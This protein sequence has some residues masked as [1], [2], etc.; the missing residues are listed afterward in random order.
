MTII[1]PPPPPAPPAAPPVSAA[2]PPLTPGGRTAVRV[3]LVI[4]ASVVVVGT[5]LSLGATAWGVSMF[6]VVADETAF[7]SD[8][9]SLVID[10]GDVPAALRLRT[11]RDAREPR[12]SMRLLKS[13]RSGERTL[14]VNQDAQTTRITVNG[15]TPEFMGWGRAGEIT[16]TLPPEMARRLSVTT[17]Q[18]KGVLLVQA[19]LDSLVAS[20]TYG[21]VIL[22]GSARRIDVTGQDGT[23]LTRDPISVSES[24]VAE[25]V[26][27]EISVDFKEAPP[28]TVEA[29]TR[30]GD[31]VIS[32]PTPGP[33]L[34]RASGDSA[35]VRV[36]ETTDPAR[37]AAQITARSD[38][39]DVVVEGAGAGRHR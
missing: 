30:T 20:N 17:T 14:Q 1:A 18:D 25:S 24:F 35:R 19:D 7:P 3:F 23:V 22:S 5:V 13:A 12:V 16:V 2:P 21:A 36:P 27:G 28:R 34:V 39:G 32:L 8:T 26:D 4:A 33:Y 15:V 31:I 6:R 10:T 9:R 11:D 38:E 29:S 37:A